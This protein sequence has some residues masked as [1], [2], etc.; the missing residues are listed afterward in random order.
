MAAFLCALWLEHRT[1]ISLPTP[2]GSFAVGRTTDFW[3]SNAEDKTAPTAGIKRQLL[4]WI[5]YPTNPSSATTADYMDP[6]QRAAIE[7][8]RGPINSHL[9]TRDHTKVLTHSFLNAALS[10]QQPTYPIIVMRSGA[11]AEVINYSTLAEDLA[12]HGYVVV[13]FDA[14]YRT[15]V[16][17]LPNGQVVTRTPENNLEAGTVRDQVNRLN[18][19]LFA[20]TA[21]VGFALDKLQ[22]LNASDPSGRFTGHLDLDRV[23]VFGHSFGGATAAQF[24]HD[25]ARCKAGIDIDGN[26]FGTVASAE[27]HQPFLFLLSDHNSEKDPVALAILA[28]I[29]STYDHQPPE[30]RLRIEIRG[31]NH[32]FFSDDSALLKSHIVLWMLRRLGLVHIEGPRQLEITTYS[33]H[34]FF[35]AY[36]KDKPISPLQAPSPQFP[37]LRILP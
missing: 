16:V 22:Q 23:G 10:T 27:I 6:T 32:Y 5:W 3:T 8:Y 31:A 19:V 36:L 21:D 17:V 33:V 1:P 12:S 18:E 15:S 30:T 34:T 25:D 14:P 24:C 29:Q 11:S 26:L 35:D 9:L 28:K 7:R 37:E 2:T 20:W 4:V 13:A